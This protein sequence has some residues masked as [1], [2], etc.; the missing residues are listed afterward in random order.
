MKRSWSVNT[1]LQ[2][3]AGMFAVNLKHMMHSNLWTMTWA[4]C[5]SR[6]HYF[7]VIHC[8][9]LPHTT[10]CS[11]AEIQFTWREIKPTLQWKTDYTFWYYSKDEK[12]TLLGMLHVLRKCWG[13]WHFH[14]Q[15]MNASS[16]HVK[17]I[18]GKKKISPFSICTT[19]CHLW[20]NFQRSWRFFKDSRV[21]TTESE[22]SHILFTNAVGQARLW[23]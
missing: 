19:T 12:R 2:L 16:Q 13:K 7:H 18:T 4:Y 6:P 11:T 15:P 20:E 5:D 17:I 9:G 21:T 14:S 23:I 10:K 3:R 1:R 22:H 8:V